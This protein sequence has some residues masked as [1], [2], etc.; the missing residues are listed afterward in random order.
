MGHF[1]NALL[2]VRGDGHADSWDVRLNQYAADHG[3]GCIIPRL[4]HVI[5]IGTQDATHTKGED[6][7]QDEYAGMEDVKTLRY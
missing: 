2:P 4:C 7:R 3:M 1:W 5:N 6:L